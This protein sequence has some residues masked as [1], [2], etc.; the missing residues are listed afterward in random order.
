MIHYLPLSTTLALDWLR[1][2]KKDTK[3]TK[4]F[5]ELF[6]KTTKDNEDEVSLN[7]WGVFNK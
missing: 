3:K 1:M 6:L 4:A 7:I 5:N 2:G